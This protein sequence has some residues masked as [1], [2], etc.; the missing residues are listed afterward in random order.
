MNAAKA[1]PPSPT[2]EFMDMKGVTAHFGL[3]E[4]QARQLDADGLIKS[5]SLRKKGKVRGSRLYVA[6]SIRDYLNSLAKQ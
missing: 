3:R 4:S 2:A 6:Q 1:E 5:V